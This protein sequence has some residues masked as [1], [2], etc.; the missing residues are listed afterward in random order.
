MKVLVAGATGVVGREVV[1][2]LNQTGHFVR[3]LSQRSERA[4]SLRRI[5]DE[6]RVL[7]A[8]KANVSEVA[9][10]QISP[11]AQAYHTHRRPVRADRA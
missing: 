8:T 3:T 9:H 6:V 1:L 7:D 4:E 2:L 5:A 10:D 11:R